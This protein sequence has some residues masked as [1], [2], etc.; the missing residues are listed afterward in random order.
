M[1]T[2]SRNKNQWVTYALI[3]LVLALVISNI[4]FIRQVNQLQP[5]VTTLSEEKVKMK[6]EADSLEAQIEQVT[7]GKIKQSAQ[8][9]AINDSLKAKISVLQVKLKKGH[10]TAVELAK[11]KLELAELKE[12]VKSY[13]AQIDV[14]KKKNDSLKTVS[15]TL[16]S[17]L[18]VVNNKAAN[19]EKS[20]QELDNK[21][22]IGAALKLATA[23]V[24]PY[25]IR[26][27]GKEIVDD[28]APKVKK[29]KI[30]FTLA[31]NALA[32]IGVHDIFAQVIDP[33]GNVMKASDTAPFTADGKELQST[34]RT[35]IDFKDDGS[36]Y[37]LTWLNATT[38]APGIYTVV[39][40]A[41]GYTMGK[42]TFELKK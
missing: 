38:M 6:S 5:K 16:K 41:D 20:N 12:N 32:K 3:A 9:L 33:S 26:K 39:F 28:Y 42:T 11:V 24:T 30:N 22:K 4:Y 19:L 27:S 21:V 18:A 23:S 29:I 17:N 1:E 40:F 37:T 8:M 15:D 14:L 7:E 35:S 31:I 2:N 36:V 13:I 34:I 10:L 25:K